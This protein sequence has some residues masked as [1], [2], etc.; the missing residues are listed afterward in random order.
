MKRWY[1]SKTVLAL[2]PIILYY[3]SK[4]SGVEITESEITPLFEAGT[5]VVLWV[6]AIY[7][8]FKAKW[9]LK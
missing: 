5:T 6:L 1:K 9:P 8:R 4:I 7:W 2:L 3:L